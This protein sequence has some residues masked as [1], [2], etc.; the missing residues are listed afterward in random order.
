MTDALERG[1][2]LHSGELSGTDLIMD[3][4][5]EGSGLTGRQFLQ[6]VDPTGTAIEEDRKSVV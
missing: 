4:P 1:D 3:S 2:S 6:Q 5:I